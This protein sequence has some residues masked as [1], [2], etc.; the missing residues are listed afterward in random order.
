MFNQSPSCRSRVFASNPVPGGPLIPTSVS[1]TPMLHSAIVQC[2]RPMTNHISASPGNSPTC[3]TFDFQGQLLPPSARPCFIVPF[4]FLLRAYIASCRACLYL[5]LRSGGLV[6]VQFKPGKNNDV[7][8]PTLAGATR[9]PDIACSCLHLGLPCAVRPVSLPAS[10]A[11]P[12][13]SGSHSLSFA[14]PSLRR[15]LYSVDHKLLEYRRS[16][17][18]PITP[19][20]RE[21]V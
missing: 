2:M 8:L 18:A 7:L 11:N 15:P 3:V 6:T 5:P 13:L 9:L 14:R 17:F 16:G 10:S 19:N 4:F 1:S 12:F 20:R 21:G